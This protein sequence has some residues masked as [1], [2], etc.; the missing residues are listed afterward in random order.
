MLFVP[1]AVLVVGL[2][3]LLGY[4]HL[5]FE[6]NRT[7]VVRQRAAVPARRRVKPKAVEPQLSWRTLV[8][9]AP[10]EHHRGRRRDGSGSGR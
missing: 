8:P 10:L 3:L 6:E 1:I 5:L 7:R 9:A 4:S 2:L